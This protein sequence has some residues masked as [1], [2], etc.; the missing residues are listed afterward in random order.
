MWRGGAGRCEAGW[1]GAGRRGE[2]VGVVVVV[3]C[4]WKHVGWLRWEYVGWLRWD[5]AALESPPP[6]RR[7]QLSSHHLERIVVVLS[8]EE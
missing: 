8:G 1:C 6:R 7:A 5:C 4:V 2:R 3:V